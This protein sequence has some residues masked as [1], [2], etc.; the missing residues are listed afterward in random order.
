MPNW[1]SNTAN[2]HNDNIEEVAK[3]ESF[4]KALDEREKKSDDSGLFS[5]FSPIPIVES[6]N[7][8]DWNISNWGTKWEASIYS[9]EKLSDNHIVINF[10]TAWAPPI[11]FYQYVAENTEFYV[12]A[13]YWEP[14]MGFVGCSIGGDDE[15]Y[16]YSCME[17]L[18]HIPE[19]LIKEYNLRDQFYELVEDEEEL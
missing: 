6:E 4:L 19:G 15:Y 5:Y 9:W 8:Y 12:N 18:K 3:L 14:S 17:D 7:W 11:P 2:F 13:T 1:C 16:E 10:D